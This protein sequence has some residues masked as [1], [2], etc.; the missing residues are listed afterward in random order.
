MQS[1]NSWRA[2]ASNPKGFKQD[3]RGGFPL[4]K[5]TF[6]P[7]E[8]LR[9]NTGVELLKP[10]ASSD[11]KTAFWTN[12]KTLAD[13]FDKEFQRKYAND[14]DT[15]LIFVRVYMFHQLTSLI[16]NPRLVFSLLS[17]LHSLFRSSQNFSQIPTLQHKYSS[18]HWFITSPVLVLQESR[19]LNRLE[20][21]KSF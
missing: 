3:L 15:S 4:H 10:A 2:T 20:P 18:W 11:K 7:D 5:L 1:I 14:L 8:L 12:Y 13:E 19:C 17:A 16:S 9:L 6:T 21:P